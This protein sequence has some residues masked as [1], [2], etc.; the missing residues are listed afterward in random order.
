[1][2][3]LSTAILI[4]LIAP[5]VP[6]HAQAAGA[7]SPAAAP[8]GTATVAITLDEAISRAKA[9][10]PGFA[11]A[12]AAS[13]VSNLD[14]SIARAALLP[15]ATYHNQFLYTQP[16]N[17]RTGSA[18]ASAESP[19][20]TS[21]PRFIAN[22]AVHEYTSQGIVTETIGLQQITAVSRADAT[23]AVA[24]AELEITRRGLTATVVSLF[25]GSIAADHKVALANP[26]VPFERIFDV[27]QPR[28]RAGQSSQRLNIGPAQEANRI[29]PRG[30]PAGE[31][32]AKKN[33]PAHRRNGTIVSRRRGEAAVKLGACC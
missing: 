26:G 27:G 17:G 7:S 21:P 13:R 23:A 2:V 32:Q 15:S 8:S 9:N 10:E 24:S 5:N 20:A 33:K 29:R 28:G 18:N 22:N 19:A 12:V 31:R 25:Y 30:R 6:L 16:A 11:A 1:M 4:L 14:R 3:R